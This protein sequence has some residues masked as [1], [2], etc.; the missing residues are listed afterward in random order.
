MPIRPELRHFYR[1][2]EWEAT[3][4]R[5]LQRAGDKCEQCGK[6]NH[7][8]AYTVCTGTEMYW[9]LVGSSRWYSHRGTLIPTRF[10]MRHLVRMKHPR[11]PRRIY[12]ILT[13][14]HLDHTPGHDDDANLRAW[15][16]WCHLHHDQPHHAETR[17]ARKDLA[18]P[19]LQLTQE[20]PAEV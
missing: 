18:R 11:P 16:Q 20:V 6:P 7:A 9:S 14:A 3:R 8:A 13:V 1:G 17:A 5:I 4:K 10:M 2:P 15:C 19:L 12:V